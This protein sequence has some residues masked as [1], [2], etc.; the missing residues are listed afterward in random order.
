MAYLDATTRL[1]PGGGPRAQYVGFAASVSAAISGTL[2][3]STEAEIVAGGQTIIITLTADTWIAD[4]TGQRQAI[5][6]GITS[7]QSEATGWNNEVRDNEV[8]GAVV[9]TS[10]TIVTITLTAAPAYDI[11]ADETI[12]VTI[13]AAA[14]TSA[15]EVVATPTVSVVADVSVS[16]GG[17]GSMGYVPKRFRRSLRALSLRTQPMRDEEV[18]E[19]IEKIIEEVIDEVESVES[20]VEDTKVPGQDIARLATR[21]VLAKQAIIRSTRKAEKVSKR[22]AEAQIQARINELVRQRREFFLS[23]D[24]D[25]QAILFILSEIV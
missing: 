3:G 18:E 16:A 9:R 13:P 7:A 2:D 20:Q 24:E 17:G 25:L 12:T 21:R 4:I 19:Q 10:D 15:Q 6:D 23:E 1:G 8:V 14:L 22:L 11:T 5:I